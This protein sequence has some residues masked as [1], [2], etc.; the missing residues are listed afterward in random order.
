MRIKNNA[1]E[2]L[3][4]EKWEASSIIFNSKI[5]IKVYSKEYLFAQVPSNI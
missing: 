1:I 3:F 2:I 4:E 5:T